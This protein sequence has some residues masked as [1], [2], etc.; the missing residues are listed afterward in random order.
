MPVLTTNPSK[1]AR[2]HPVLYAEHIRPTLKGCRGGWL[3]AFMALPYYGRAIKAYL[4]GWSYM[5]LTPG[6]YPPC[7]PLGLV[8]YALHRR[9]GGPL[10]F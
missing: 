3:Y 4:W 1:A 6:R 5:V 9:L 7:N 2:G 10:F 8:F